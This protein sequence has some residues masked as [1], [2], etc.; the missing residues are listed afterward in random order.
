MD[1]I[2][3][4]KQLRQAIQFQVVALPDEQ[5]ILI[6]WYFR[7][8]ILLLPIRLVIGYNMAICYTNVC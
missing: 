5:A 1:K 4:A 8:G 3:M 2:Q 7:G 6:P